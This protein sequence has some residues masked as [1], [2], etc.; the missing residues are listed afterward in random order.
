[1][2]SLSDLEQDIRI[3]VGDCIFTVIEEQLNVAARR[4]FARTHAWKADIPVSLVAN[5]NTYPLTAPT[6]TAVINIDYAKYA[7]NKRPL[8]KANHPLAFDNGVTSARPC[9]YAGNI[10]SE[11]M[12]Y[13]MP[14]AALD[15]IVSVS[16]QPNRGSYEIPDNLFNE[17][18][19]ALVNGALSYLLSMPNKEWTNP[20]E[21]A[22][23]SRDFQRAIVATRTRIAQ[24]GNGQSGRMRAPSFL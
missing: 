6:G 11:L 3:Y 24:G 17:H 13:P 19:D 23:Y 9:Y 1:M 8:S 14:T 15:I 2:A 16:L 21:A 20:N 18:S 5:D 10:A 7:D 12:V 4:F 22:K